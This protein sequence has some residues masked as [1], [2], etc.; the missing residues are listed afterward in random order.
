MRS[1]SSI[2]FS[3]ESNWD[4]DVRGCLAKLGILY[5]RLCCLHVLSMRMSMHYHLKFFHDTE[6]IK[7]HS[8]CKWYFLPCFYLW[9]R[10]PT[11]KFKFPN[12]WWFKFYFLFMW[13][14]DIHSIVR[15][16]DFEV[17][18]QQDG[19]T[20]KVF[21]ARGW[22]LPFSSCNGG[23][24]GL[25]CSL[26]STCTMT[27]IHPFAYSIHS[28]LKKYFEFCCF[29]TS[30]IKYNLFCQVTVS[31]TWPQPQRETNTVL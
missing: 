1:S 18:G 24:R 31:H 3:W 10:L 16:L 15:C 12:S 11:Y 13:G 9:K 21:A 14:S 20:S 26:I 7:T 23:R 2:F 17:R 30:D 19:S 27:C 5:Y 25:T 22:W 4:K 29:W 8:P 6:M 28:F